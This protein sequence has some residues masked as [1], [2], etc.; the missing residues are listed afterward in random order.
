MMK[1]AIQGTISGLINDQSVLA[2]CNGCLDTDGKAMNHFSL[3][4]VEPVPKG[5]N[6]FV[7]GNCYKSS[8]HPN[9]T[10]WVNPNGLAPTS[11]ADL[12]DDTYFTSRRVIGP[13]LQLEFK[14]TVTREAALLVARDSTVN[15]YYDGPLDIVGVNDYVQEW[16]AGETDDSILI[17]I[18]ANLARASGELVPVSIETRYSNLTNRARDFSR[19]QV[20]HIYGNQSW[21]GY[22]MKLDWVAVGY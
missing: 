8:Y 16:S 13:G 17:N 6:P 7:A 4:F 14:S 20:K 1:L 3:L 18:S 22:E 9:G 19:R 15:G 10:I 2:I 21:D 12:Y 5:F 11:F